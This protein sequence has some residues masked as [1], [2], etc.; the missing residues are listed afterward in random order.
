MSAA[1]APSS[2]QPPAAPSSY[3]PLLLFLR[4]SYCSYFFSFAAALSTL[5][6]AAALNSNLL[7]YISLSLSLNPVA[8]APPLVPTTAPPPLNFSNLLLLLSLSLSLSVCVY[9][10][11]KFL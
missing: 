2:T 9:L 8:A 5:H 10:S 11:L 7:L 6:D 4:P 3:A 1:A